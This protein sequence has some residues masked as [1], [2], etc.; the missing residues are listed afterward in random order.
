VT[1][2]GTVLALVLFFS[3]GLTPAGARDGT[4]TVDVFLREQGGR[5][6]AGEDLLSPDGDGQSRS[7]IVSDQ[8]TVIVKVQNDG[9][10]QRT[11][12]LQAS[13]AN[14]G[15]E[16][17]YLLR[18]HNVT[19]EVLHGLLELRVAP[20]KER[21][22]KVVVNARDAA[23]AAVQPVVVIASLDDEATDAARAEIT[24]IS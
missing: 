18:G 24:K 16:L 9:A 14:D 23:F 2:G 8:I 7:L 15:Y 4:G 21:T 5:S 20:G 1:R 13:P 22:L 17:S 19:G 12:T 6:F 10:E 3:L 11:F